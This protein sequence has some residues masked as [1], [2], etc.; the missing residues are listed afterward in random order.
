MTRLVVAAAALALVVPASSAQPPPELR[1][2]VLVESGSATLTWTVIGGVVRGSHGTA[3]VSFSGS[4]GDGKLDVSGGG[5]TRGPLT[6]TREERATVCGLGKAC[7]SLC[8]AP[9]EKT[10][11]PGGVSFKVMGQQVKVTWN[12]PSVEPKCALILPPQLDQEL[13]RGGLLSKTVP[14]ALFRK[15]DIT[16]KLSG[17]PL[18]EELLPA[19]GGRWRGTYAWQF[20]LNLV[21]AH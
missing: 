4:G 3:R 7:V 15:R 11:E 12:F 13:V 9:H 5:T 14:L 19:G 2:A 1:F 6:V 20:I 8:P 16:L 17:S 21:A 10:Q 18:V